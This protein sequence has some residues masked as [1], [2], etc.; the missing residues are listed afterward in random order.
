MRPI[1][2]EWDKRKNRENL[3]KHRIDFEEARK[4]F[5]GAMTLWA[6]TRVE[7]GEERWIGVGRVADRTIVVVFSHPA[8]D[9]IRIISARKALKW[10]RQ[11][12]EKAISD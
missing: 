6:D 12:Y 5:A 11:H 2:F 9:R 4:V 3:R 10:E 7:Y 8:A 1:R